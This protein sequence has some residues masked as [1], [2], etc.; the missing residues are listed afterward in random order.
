MKRLILYSMGLL[1]L[2]GGCTSED[3]ASEV[4]LFVTQSATS[5]TG[6]EKLYFDIEA[7][8]INGYVDRLDIVSF[9]AVTGER[10]LASE[11]PGTNVYA[12]RY[13]YTA[14]IVAVDSL[15]VEVIFTATDN[16]GYLQRQ[17]RRIRVLNSA[18]PLVERSGYTIYSPHSG[19]F[20]AFSFDDLR[21]LK[22]SEADPSAVDFY[23]C[24]SPEGGEERLSR[25]WKSE[26]GATF[27]KVN[28]F[29]YAGAT[30]S[31]VVSLYENSR[32]D[33]FVDDLAIDDVILLGRDGRAWGVVKI[34]AI[35]DEPGTAEDRYLFNLKTVAN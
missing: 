23:V 27:A 7:R 2:C 17:S 16:C 20:D 18:E 34:V 31:A 25:M 13:V 28:A 21:P 30:R 33:D 22:R 24:P 1:A 12:M 3:D 14:P 11:H 15:S 29:D 4:L 26:T 6:G 8:T 32:S 9:D 10:E 5:L 35:F 19:K